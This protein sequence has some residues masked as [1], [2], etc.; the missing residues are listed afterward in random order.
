MTR[1]PRAVY[2]Q[3]RASTKSQELLKVKRYLDCE[4]KIVGW[5]ELMHNGNV[6]TTNELGQTAR[7]SHQANKTGLNTLGAI[8]CQGIA[9]TPFDGIEFD[10][11]NGPGLDDAMRAYIWANREKLQG[12]LVKFKYFPVGM[13]EKPR[14][15]GYLGLRAE[16]DR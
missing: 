11:G 9:G 8:E 7:S 4:A 6:A 16:I 3:G 2:K 15:P 1:D 12:T 5:K 10:V 13:K 14:H